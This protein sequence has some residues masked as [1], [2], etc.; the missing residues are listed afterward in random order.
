MNTQEQG[1]MYQTT[2]TSDADTGRPQYL[3]GNDNGALLPIG[4]G[5]GELEWDNAPLPSNLSVSMTQ[6]FHGSMNNLNLNP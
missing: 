4:T 6:I 2:A 3:S 5:I 1:A